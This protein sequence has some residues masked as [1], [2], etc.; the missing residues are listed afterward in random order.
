MTKYKKIVI[1]GGLILLA[2]LIL[3]RAYLS[4]FHWGHIKVTGL[5]CTCPDEEV[6][7]GQLYLKNIT[8]DSLKKYNLDYSEIYV[9]NKPYNPFFD[10]MGVDQYFIK[11]QVIG[12]DRVSEGYPW[13]PRVRVDMWKVVNPFID[14]GIKGLYFGQLIIL[15]ILLRRER[16]KTKWVLTT[17]S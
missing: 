11:G 1:V 7:G 9:T 4:P 8:P 2:Q 10:P 13:N 16:K 5:A 14:W 15:I 17:L 12:K 6:L 3:F